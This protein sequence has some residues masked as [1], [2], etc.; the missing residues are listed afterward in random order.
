MIVVGITGNFSSGKSTVSAVF[1]KLGAQLFDADLA[2]KKV[3]RKGTPVYRAIV[4][5]FGKE[6]LDKKG[7]LDRR[8]LAERVFSHPEE[9]KKLNILIHPEVILEAMKIK[10]QFKNREGILVFDVPLLYEA[11]MEK[12]V[13]RV[14]VVN[15]TRSAMISRGIQ[16]GVKPALSKKILSSQWPLAKKASRADFV[17]ENDG[18]RKGM[19]KQARDIYREILNDYETHKL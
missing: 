1:K 18:N 13:D 16:K 10:K 19:E 7:E 8:R 4:Q 12:L 17:I 6:F 11:K 15:A 14:V 5:I 2:A 9:L 3:A